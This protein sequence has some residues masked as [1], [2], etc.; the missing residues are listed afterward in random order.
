MRQN[1]VCPL[2]NSEA[3]DL[4]RNKNVYFE[5]GFAT[6]MKIPVIW[7][8]RKGHEFTFNTSQYPHLKPLNQHK[9]RSKP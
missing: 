1:S 5:A 2:C 4:L 6:G 3:Y 9:T 7:T 8:Y